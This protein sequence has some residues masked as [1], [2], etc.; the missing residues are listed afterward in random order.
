MVNDPLRDDGVAR[1]RVGPQEGQEV[2]CHAD[3]RIAAD[4]AK[5]LDRHTRMVL[6]GDITYEG[7]APKRIHV[8]GFTTVPGTLPTLADVHA[9]RLRPPN[10]MSVEEYLDELRDDG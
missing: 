4:L 6:Y 3:P 5:Y 2:S 8:E 1:L 10:G 7:E 9:L